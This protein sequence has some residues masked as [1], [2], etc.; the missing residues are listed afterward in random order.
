[1]KKKQNPKITVSIKLKKELDKLSIK[2]GDTYKEIIWRLLD[3]KK[4]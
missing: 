3:G 1:M 2:K 4:K